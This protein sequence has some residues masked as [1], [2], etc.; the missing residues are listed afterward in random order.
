MLTSI[1]SAHDICATEALA[2]QHFFRRAN[3]S[4]AAQFLLPWGSQIP[5]CNETVVVLSGEGDDLGVI[6]NVFIRSDSDLAA[7]DMRKLYPFRIKL[8]LNLFPCVPTS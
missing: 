2:I 4:S 5:T 8:P 7:F 1:N 6:V 3:L